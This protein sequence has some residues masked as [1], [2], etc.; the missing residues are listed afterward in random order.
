LIYEDYLLSKGDTLKNIR[1]SRID[2]VHDTI[3][4]E[5]TISFLF[6]NDSILNYSF[7]RN[8][9]IGRKITGYIQDSC[10][11]SEEL[12]LS[13]LNKLCGTLLNHLIYEGNRASIY[14]PQLAK[15]Y[16][17]ALQKLLLILNNDKLNFLNESCLYINNDLFSLESLYLSYKKKD[18][19]LFKICLAY[20]INQFDETTKLKFE[21]E[22]FDLLDK[23]N[24]DDLNNLFSSKKLKSIYHLYTS[25]STA[26]LINK[27]CWLGYL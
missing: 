1:V 27:N 24:F 18:K 22:W 7:E 4:T 19:K 8:P 10:K 2:L 3:Y 26:Y 15:R 23:N 21:E 12:L 9:G 14:T 16:F 5:Q 20:R 25:K 17:D 6:E 13:R 11:I